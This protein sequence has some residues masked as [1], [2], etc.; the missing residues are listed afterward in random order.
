M[1]HNSSETL[2]FDLQLFAENDPDSNNPGT[3]PIE[4]GQQAIDDGEELSNIFEAEPATGG[5][6]QGPSQKPKDEAGSDSPKYEI[7][8][9]QFDASDIKRWQE[10]E[11]GDGNEEKWKAK[12]NRRGQEL[13]EQESTLKQRE[14]SV[15]TN[16]SL[17]DQYKQFKAVVD[18]NPDAR[19]YFKKVVDNPQNA[20]KPALDKI[21]AGIDERFDDLDVQKAEVSLGKE[22]KDYDSEVCDKA[23]S[24]YDPDNP[25]DVAKMKYY[26]WKGMNMEIELQKRI[27]SGEETR[28]PGLPP[29]ATGAPQQRGPKQYNSP[30]EAA[31]AVIRDLGLSI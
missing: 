18:S 21:Q 20:M 22:F 28:V 7:D 6:P 19:E 12:L 26:V 16:Q 3:Q 4:P 31:D 25:Y 11:K 15:V 2:K 30:A 17:L 23:I 27:A 24:V 8:G 1:N 9:V 29:V 13:N 10:L 5:D 14:E